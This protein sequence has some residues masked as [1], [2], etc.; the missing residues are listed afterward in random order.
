MRKISGILMIFALVG[1][2]VPFA[3]AETVT[4][5]TEEQWL[6][7]TPSKFGAPGLYSIFNS[8]TYDKGR[9][10]VGLYF[11]LTRFC[12]PGDPRYPK[13][14]EFTLGGAYGI[15]EKFEVFASAPMNFLNIPKAPNESRDPADLAV[16][17][18]VSE[19]GIGD[20][21]LGVRYQVADWFTPYVQAFLP[22][23][24]SEKGLGGDN[25][26]I[27]LGGSFGT[28][29][30]STRLYGQLA[31]QLATAYDQDRRDFS[32]VDANYSRPRYERFGTNPLFREYGN[33][34]LYSAGLAIPIVENV[35]EVFSEFDF[36]HSFDDPD[37][38]PM[39][40]DGKELDVVQDGGLF[41]GGVRAGFGNG[42]ALTVA[43]GAKIFA[44][45]PMYESPHYRY[46]AGLTYSPLHEVIYERIIP[47]PVPTDPIVPLPG[48][49]SEIPVGPPIGGVE[50]FDC[51]QVLV[52]AH[53]DFDRSNLTPE[54]IAALQRV[55]KYMRL[56]GNTMLEVQGHTD[57]EGTEN[58]N[59][60]LGNR[61][62]RAA[63]YYLVYDEGIDP[64]RIVGAENLAKGIVAGV[65][66]GESVPIASNETDAGRAQNRR[67]QFVKV[68]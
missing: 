20:L 17:D 25:T 37:Y 13:L 10:G 18:D 5:T 61:R 57:W 7:D 28:S 15:T 9:F 27:Q 11:D 1:L 38:I 24:D 6:T 58:Y 30:G 66:Y 3:N 31:Y 26:R 22:T 49:G 41:L 68:R 40:E 29:V 42:I 48:A 12:L 46:S 23:S 47:D 64:S 19:S 45:E 43:G 39:F 8:T 34:L 63:V 51:E 62:A 14:M 32:E 2:M 21:G 36:Y 16:Q 44:E 33:T 65:S 56:C 35:V 50:D 4:Y 60:G 53:F 59:Y 55:G 52:M 54:A 67:A